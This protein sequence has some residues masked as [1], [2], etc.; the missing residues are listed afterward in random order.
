[1]TPHEYNT[2]LSAEGWSS[3]VPVLA[4][5]IRAYLEIEAPDPPLSTKDLMEGLYPQQFAR[6][7]GITM[8]QKMTRILIDV[9]S[10]NE[11]ADCCT[12]GE[13]IIRR[14]RLV[15]PCFWHAPKPKICEHCGKELPL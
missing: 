7:D 11:L 15:R 8:R 3:I 9:L 13:A 6:G 10:K 1:M 4:R 2:L 5:E 12:R 14:K